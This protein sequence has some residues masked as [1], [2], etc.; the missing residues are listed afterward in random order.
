MRATR[1]ALPTVNLLAV[2]S[3]T[4][5]LPAAQSGSE[6]VVCVGSETRILAINP[7]R[8]VFAEDM[9][10]VIPDRR[11]HRPARPDGVRSSLGTRLLCGSVVRVLGVRGRPSG[12]HQLQGRHPLGSDREP[13]G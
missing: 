11:G 6:A 8:S 2:A 4:D 13:A 3:T 7:I 10:V 5:S 9:E 1:L 12:D